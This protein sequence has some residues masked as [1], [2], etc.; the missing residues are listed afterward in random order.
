MPSSS[1]I[2]TSSRG[3]V[4]GFSTTG[5]SSD[6]IGGGAVPLLLK[7]SILKNAVLGGSLLNEKTRSNIMV[8]TI[9]SSG[10]TKSIVKSWGELLNSMQRLKFGKSVKP[11]KERENIRFIF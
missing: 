9:T 3:R 8:G 5:K 2:P 1:Y 7:N 4:K 11:E 6:L 10:P